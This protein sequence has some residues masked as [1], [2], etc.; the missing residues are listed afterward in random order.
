MAAGLNLHKSCKGTISELE[1]AISSM[2]PLTG[3]EATLSSSP[4]NWGATMIG[5]TMG[6]V[7]S[8]LVFVLNLF[9]GAEGAASSGFGFCLPVSGF[10]DTNATKSK[11]MGCVLSPFFKFLFSSAA[12]LCSCANCSQF[13]S[14]H[15]LPGLGK[16]F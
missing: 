9:K 16:L 8:T 13:A 2:E 3:F 4:T 6:S 14:H 5:L 11:T 10:P 7:F 15:A 1:E 12:R